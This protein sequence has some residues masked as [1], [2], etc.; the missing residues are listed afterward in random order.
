[1]SILPIS[2]SLD[3]VILFTKEINSIGVTPC[4]LPTLTESISKSLERL[5]DLSKSFEFLALLLSLLISLLL[6]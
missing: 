5:L 4:F 1:M 6:V 3:F 2:I